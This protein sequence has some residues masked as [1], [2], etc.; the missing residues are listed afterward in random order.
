M[1]QSLVCQ[2]LACQFLTA[3]SRNF[4][5]FINCEDILKKLFTKL[6]T[7]TILQA[8]IGGHLVSIE[9]QSYYENVFD[10]KLEILTQLIKKFW[11][12]KILNILKIFRKYANLW[13]VNLW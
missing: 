9:Y 3:F 6:G 10:Q 8:E 11:N 7:E 1:R 4:L 5:A 2:S 12:L 13:R